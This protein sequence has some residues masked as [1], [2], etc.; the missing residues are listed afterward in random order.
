MCIKPFLIK[1]VLKRHKKKIVQIITALSTML[2]NN[3]VKKYFIDLPNTKHT[4]IN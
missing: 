3:F 4:V 2:Q 1:N